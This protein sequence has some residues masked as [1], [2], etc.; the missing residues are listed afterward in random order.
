MA[1]ID[2]ARGD[3]ASKHNNYIQYVHAYAD[4][5]ARNNIGF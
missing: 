1:V 4:T 2:V 3:P 5:H